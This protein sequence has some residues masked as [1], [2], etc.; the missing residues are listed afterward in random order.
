MK[1]AI[2]GSFATRP[3]AAKQLKHLPLDSPRT[4]LRTS[5]ELCRSLDMSLEAVPENHG[6]LADTCI[7]YIS[8]RLIGPVLPGAGHVL[9]SN[10]AIRSLILYDRSAPCRFATIKTN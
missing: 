9:F 5:L 8:L 4:I 7:A 1:T 3:P 10:T 6:I 2:I